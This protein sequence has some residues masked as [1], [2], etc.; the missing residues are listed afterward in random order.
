MG[1]DDQFA[2]AR[3]S[4]AED[5]L[6]S[7]ARAYSECHGPANWSHACGKEITTRN[8]SYSPCCPMGLSMVYRK[9]IK[10]KTFEFR[11]SVPG[12]RECTLLQIRSKA[13]TPKKCEKPLCQVCRWNPR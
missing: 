7:P 11:H 9:H 8:L 4:S 2:L 5:I 3:R 12:L 10:F 13:T 1:M 6:I